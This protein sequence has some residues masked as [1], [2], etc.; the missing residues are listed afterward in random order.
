[1]LMECSACTFH[2]HFLYI[3]FLCV[4]AIFVLDFP[5]IHVNS[6]RL[7][8]VHHSYLCLFLLPNPYNSAWYVFVNIV[9]QQI[10]IET[11][12]I[13]KNWLSPNLVVPCS[14]CNEK[15]F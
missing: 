8:S 10:F 13:F 1:M 11:N 12:F 2:R 4:I 9:I 15:G 6:K 7:G 14:M 5:L 3:F